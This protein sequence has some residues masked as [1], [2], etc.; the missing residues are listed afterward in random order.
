MNTVP[1][2]SI[3][4]KIINREIP[5]NIIYEDDRT[6]AFFTIEPINL[7]HTLIV[8]KIPCVN[9][10][11]GDPDTMG[12]LMQIA[13]KIAQ[14][15]IHTKLADGVNIIMNNERAA[16]QEVF[17][18]HLHVI[19]RRTDDHAFTPPTHVTCTPEELSETATLLTTTL[20]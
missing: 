14:A 19:P 15:L 8:P 4:T 6:I 12:H 18:A 17:H 5:A 13:Q 1:T 3:F 20:A 2:P 9:I 7:G 16:G 10:L 11:D